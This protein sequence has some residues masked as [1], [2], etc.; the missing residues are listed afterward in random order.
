MKKYGTLHL[1]FDLVLT[2]L[3]GGLWLLAII[4]KYLRTH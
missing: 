4:I 3:T 2:I 1:L